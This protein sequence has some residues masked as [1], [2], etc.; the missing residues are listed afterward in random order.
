M[1]DFD[2]RK[3]EDDVAP[4]TAETALG[5]AAP[6]NTLESQ[7][8]AKEREAADL[9][10]K[11]LRV[12]AEMENLRRRTAREVADA[13]S[14]GISGFARD[15]LN[16]ADN[17]RRALD[18]APAELRASRDAAALL[19]GVELTE[20]ELLKA[21]EKNGVKRF[22][23]LGEKFDPNLHQAMFEIPDETK[24][25]GTVAQVVQSGFMIG[26]R[27]LRPAMV[28]I[29]KGGVRTA[30]GQPANTPANSNDASA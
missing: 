19:E 10:D 22:D 30:P 24:P 26:D 12:L 20:R 14:Y 28:G 8:E 2:A 15:I 1:S 11:L 13:R 18:A 16:V 27:I 5:D 29:S 6:E 23:P 3:P 21:L 17:M 7:Y 4:Q 25:A 9:K